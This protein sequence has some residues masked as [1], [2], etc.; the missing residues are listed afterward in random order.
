MRALL[1][2]AALFLLLSP[3]AHAQEVVPDT[4][5]FEKA[6]VTA[7]VSQD[8]G[9]VAGT[10]TK[11]T[12]QTIKAQLLDGKNAGQ[13]ITVDNDYL[14][15]ATSEVFY[16]MH[17]VN[18]LEG[19]DVYAVSE[20]YRLPVIEFFVALLSCASSCSA[21][22]RACAGFSRSTQLLFYHLPAFAGDTGGYPP[23]WVALGVSALI[24]VLGSYITHG[25]TRTTT[26]AVLGMLA[27][28]AV[29]AV[30]AYVAVHAAHLSGFT[31]EETVSLNFDTQG[32]IDFVGLLL[33]G[34]LIGML[35]ILYDAAIGQAI[36]VEE[37][38][39]AGAPLNGARNLCTRLEDRPRAY[40]RP[41]EHAR[42]RLCGRGASAP[43]FIQSVVYAGP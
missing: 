26:T 38:M 28:V 1:A 32:T 37:L 13:I 18:S 11:T 43:P 24:I 19:R 25:F 23:M 29:T 7:V 16:L 30:L 2:A 40:R 15:M 39:S 5:T 27:T 41:G 36:A 31:N 42:D 6:K 34:M 10:K 3:L 21:G 22:S 20:P 17:T 9:L 33:G 12:Y 4:V 35:G 8:S 14:A